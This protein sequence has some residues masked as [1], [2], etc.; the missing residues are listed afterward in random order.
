[1]RD[2]NKKQNKIKQKLCQPNNLSVK[3][4]FGSWTIKYFMIT[5]MTG[6]MLWIE[7]CPSKIHI[8]KP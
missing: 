3:M 6:R 7:L 2:L 4:E 8:L 1:M 5:M